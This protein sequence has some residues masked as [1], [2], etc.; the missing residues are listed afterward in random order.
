LLVMGQVNGM[1]N[2]MSLLLI[3]LI[4]PGLFFGMVLWCTAPRLLQMLRRAAAA[5]R[6]PVLPAR[7]AVRVRMAGD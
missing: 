3:L 2:A 7:A 4:L 1:E 6:A 5:R